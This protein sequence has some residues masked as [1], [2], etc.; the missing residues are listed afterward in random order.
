MP[1]Q[2]KVLAMPVCFMVRKNLSDFAR[3]GC[4]LDEMTDKPDIQLLRDYAESGNE[5]AFREIVSRY[6]NLVYSAALRQVGS[7]DKAGDVAQSAF[8]DLARKAKQLAGKFP[9]GSS[10]MGW[11]YRAT[12]LAALNQL[13]SERR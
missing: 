1:E 5:A 4:L 6:T 8:I 10:L 11:L 7:H 2:K 3:A 13:R 9:A 12:R